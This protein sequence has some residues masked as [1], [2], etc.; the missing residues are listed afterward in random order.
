MA[1]PTVT[2][3]VVR[4]I[5]L[6]TSFGCQSSSVYHISAIIW[7]SQQKWKQFVPD[8]VAFLADLSLVVTPEKIGQFS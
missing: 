7:Y 6:I 8:L 1:L 3:V 4:P 2:P 5:R